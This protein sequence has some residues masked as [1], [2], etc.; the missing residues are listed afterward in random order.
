[1]LIFFDDG[2]RAEG[3]YTREQGR[4]VLGRM[5][6]GPNDNFHDPLQVGGSED[7]LFKVLAELEPQLEQQERAHLR[8]LKEE[9]A[10]LKAENNAGQN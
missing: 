2:I 1:M 4:E 7:T 3:A 9:Q 10:Q 5:T 8:A 6:I